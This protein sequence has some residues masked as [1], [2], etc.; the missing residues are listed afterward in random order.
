MPIK[1][2]DIV[3]QLFYSGRNLCGNIRKS[4]IKHITAG[5]EK[6]KQF[7]TEDTGKMEKIKD[8]QGWGG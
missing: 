8:K 1:I 3:K 7:D 6:K 2:F 5:T 4:F